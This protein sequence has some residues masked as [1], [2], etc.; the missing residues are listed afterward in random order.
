MYICVVAH[1]YFL[2]LYANW[3]VSM[4]S[5]VIISSIKGLSRAPTGMTWP[6]VH[7]LKTTSTCHIRLRDGADR[8]PHRDNSWQP[9]LVC[10]DACHGRIHN[11]FVLGL[12]SLKRLSHFSRFKQNRCASGLQFQK[13]V[14]VS[15]KTHEI[16]FLPKYFSHF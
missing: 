12:P 2:Y 8:H 14:H 15:K 9:C 4:S 13:I 11:T 5:F 7:E 1:T 3:N 16:V 10:I 6:A